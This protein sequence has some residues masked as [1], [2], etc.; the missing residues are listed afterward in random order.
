M[1]ATYS[2]PG[3]FTIGGLPAP[4]QSELRDDDSEALETYFKTD[5]AGGIIRLVSRF[6]T[7]SRIDRRAYKT[8]PRSIIGSVQVSQSNHPA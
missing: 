6:W 3:R 4:S 8:L 7:N 1:W 2:L 5:A